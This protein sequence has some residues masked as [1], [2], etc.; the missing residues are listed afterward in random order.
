MKQGCRL[1]G[2]GPIVIAAGLACLPLGCGRHEPRGTAA[3]REIAAVVKLA[4][5]PWFNRMEEGV[6]A[7]GAALGVAVSQVGPAE[8]DEA[9]Q[10]RLIEDLITKGVA[11]ICVVPNDAKSLEPV[12][13]RARQSGI[14]IVTHESP[15]QRE[16]D[17]DVELIDNVRFGQYHWDKLVEMM[18]EE[19]DYAVFVGSLTVP[20]HNLWADAGLEHARLKYPR[21]RLVTERIPCSEDQGLARQKTLELLQTYPGLKGIIGFGSLGPIGAAQAVREKG[22]IGKVFVLGTVLPA[23]AAPYLADGSLRLGTLWD[24]KD[25]GYAMI[26]I[27]KRLLDGAPLADG[28]EIPGLGP[29]RLAGSTIV[30]DRPIE[31][32]AENA[33]SFGF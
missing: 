16:H 14:R 23:H 10:V 31:I 33:L 21:L 1:R 25:A 30:V 4:G 20:A 26:W 32:T 6:R 15:D 7:A 27:A 18:G 3:R 24:P 29:A 9:Q 22:L 19:G 12:F 2:W 8:A 5:I 28:L 17:C 11:A 13:R